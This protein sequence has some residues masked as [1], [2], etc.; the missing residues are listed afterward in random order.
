M[1]YTTNTLQSVAECD[2]LLALVSREKRGMEIRRNSLSFRNETLEESSEDFLADIAQINSELEYL[3]ET[4]PNMP[5]GNKK[6]EMITDQL[7]LTAKLRKFNARRDNFGAIGVLQRQ[8][9]VEMLN[10]N[11]V[12][13]DEFI[14]SINTRKNSL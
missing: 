7:L 1:E 12:E 3:N 14:A 5:E 11:L 9:D 13:I 2:E 8:L 4:I 6:E 10:N